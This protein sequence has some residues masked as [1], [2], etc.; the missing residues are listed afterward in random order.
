MKKIDNLTNNELAEYIKRAYDEPGPYQVDSWYIYQLNHEPSPKEQEKADKILKTFEFN[1]DDEYL[2]TL[3]ATRTHIRN[4]ILNT[5]REIE[6][7][8]SEFTEVFIEVKKDI[9]NGDVRNF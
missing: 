8:L 4:F 7:N 2:I 6:S 5:I 9:E 1:E 3:R